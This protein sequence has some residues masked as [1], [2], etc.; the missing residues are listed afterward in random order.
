MSNPAFRACNGAQG[1]SNIQLAMPG[2][3]VARL[4]VSFGRRRACAPR[5]GRSSRARIGYAMPATPVKTRSSKS[6]AM[7][8]QSFRGRMSG[9]RAGTPAGACSPRKLA[10]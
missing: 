1:R 9:S 6:G 2:G 3:P 4:D 5:V 8:P 7:A 10:S